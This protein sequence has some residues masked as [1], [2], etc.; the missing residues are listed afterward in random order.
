MDITRAVITIALAFGRG[1][2]RMA[3]FRFHKSRSILPGVRIN[4][5]KSGPSLSVGPR[6]AKLNIGPQGIR[7]TVGLPGSGLSIINRTTW[8]AGAKRNRRADKIVDAAMDGMTKDQQR[9]FAAKCIMQSSLA[10][11]RAQSEAFEAH[12]AEH[13]ADIEESDK[14]DIEGMRKIYADALAI[15][16]HEARNQTILPLSLATLAGLAMW[17]GIATANGWGIA[18]SVVLFLVAAGTDG[19]QRFLLGLMKLLM[20]LVGLFVMVVI[21]GAVV[22]FILA[23]TGNLNR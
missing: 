7:T 22:L 15:K 18:G 19:G 4:L 6:G 23:L 1:E 11:V 13:A 5:S 17:A 10:D 14:A 16:E 21:I 3:Y 8:N 20:G 12:I 9:E 2:E